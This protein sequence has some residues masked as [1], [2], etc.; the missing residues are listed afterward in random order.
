[1]AYEDYA[2]VRIRRADGVATVTADHPPIDRAA[3]TELGIFHVMVESD[4]AA[5][6]PARDDCSS[7]RAPSIRRSRLPPRTAGCGGLSRAAAQRPRSN[8]TSRP[9]IDTYEE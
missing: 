6:L 9:M 1:M 5:E 4:D 8:A 2:C 3:P 7:R